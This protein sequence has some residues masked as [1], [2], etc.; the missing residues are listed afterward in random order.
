MKHPKPQSLTTDTRLSQSNFFNSSLLNRTNITTTNSNK[1]KNQNLN[2][3]N[4]FENNSA[5]HHNKSQQHY[6]Y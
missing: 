6:T 3:R 1:G 5:I 2:L 4:S